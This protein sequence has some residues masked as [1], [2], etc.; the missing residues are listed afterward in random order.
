M[1]H[2]KGLQQRSIK[3]TVLNLIYTLGKRAIYGEITLFAETV[4]INSIDFYFCIV[5]KCTARTPWSKLARGFQWW[6]CRC[7]SEMYPTSQN[8]GRLGCI[9]R[10]HRHQNTESVHPVYLM[11]LVSMQNETHM[12]QI[13]PTFLRWCQYLKYSADGGCQV[14]ADNKFRKSSY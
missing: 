8:M 5:L 13:G 1:W 14:M 7:S 9:I 3:K 10:F 11:R 2:L 6:H 4:E 12:A